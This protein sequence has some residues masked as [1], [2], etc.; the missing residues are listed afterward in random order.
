MPT[1]SYKSQIADWKA[2]LMA[3]IAAA[4][5]QAEHGPYY[6]ERDITAESLRAY[7]ARCRAQLADPHR[8]L[9]DVLRGSP[10]SPGPNRC[11]YCGVI[12]DALMDFCSDA[13]E[14]NYDA[15]MYDMERER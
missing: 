8:S 10:M 6:P 12:I 7:A 9:K 4:E 1:P 2:D 15:G 13:C 14:G 3:D 11:R 5:E